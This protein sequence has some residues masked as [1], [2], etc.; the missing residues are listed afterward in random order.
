MGAMIELSD[1]EW[2]LVGD[3][4]DPTGRRRVT[5]RY[6]RRQMVEAILFLTRT[7]C[8]WRYLPDGYPPWEA[9]WQQWRR[10]RENGVWARA[11]ARIARSLRQQSLSDYRFVRGDPATYWYDIQY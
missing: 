8:Q 3:L 7:G 11:M 4:F 9:V 2:A 6:P 10:W 1:P 5:A